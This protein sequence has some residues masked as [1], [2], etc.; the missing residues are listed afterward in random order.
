MRRLSRL[1]EQAEHSIQFERESRIP[2]IS[3]LGNY[4]RE[5]GDES[6][7]M[8]VAVPLPLWYRRQGEI[9]TALGMKH[10]ADAERLRIQN[11]LEQAITQYVQEVHTAQEQLVVFETG[12]PN[13]PNR[14]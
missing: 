11:D 3:I 7:T 12:L 2:N 1:S 5:A 9:E 13:R 4:H 6:L 14:H 10:R 8:G